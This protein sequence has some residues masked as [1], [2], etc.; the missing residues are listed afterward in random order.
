MDVRH[1]EYYN[2]RVDMTRKLVLEKYEQQSTDFVFLQ[3][4]V[5]T[6]ATLTDQSLL[7]S[8]STRFS[9]YRCDLK[10]IA[11][12]IILLALLISCKTSQSVPL[13]KETKLF[14]NRCADSINTLRPGDSLPAFVFNPC[15]DMQTG[16]WLGMHRPIPLRKLIVNKVKNKEVLLYVINLRDERMNQVCQSLDTSITSLRYYRVP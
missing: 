7:C 3:E 13:S 6:A 1:D 11:I 10:N 16:Y 9:D 5:G 4:S 8:N 2:K 15:F 14:I 12:A